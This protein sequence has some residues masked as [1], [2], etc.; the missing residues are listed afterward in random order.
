MFPNLEIEQ[1]RRGHTDEY[2]AGKLGISPQE[3]RSGRES[4]TLAASVAD[5]LLDM[6][7]TPFEYLFERGG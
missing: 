2:V 5:I 6:Y 7:G 1:A 3:Y 4:G